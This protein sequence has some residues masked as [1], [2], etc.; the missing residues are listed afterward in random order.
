MNAYCVNCFYTGRLNKHGRCE[1]CDS[2]ATLWTDVLQAREQI[3]AA[4][5]VMKIEI[6]DRIELPDRFLAVSGFSDSEIA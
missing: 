2:E 1:S 5:P 6:P 4:T 3:P